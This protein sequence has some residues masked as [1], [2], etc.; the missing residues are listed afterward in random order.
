MVLSDAECIIDNT[1]DETTG[2]TISKMLFG[3]DQK[4]KC[5]D[6]IE[7]F[8]EE[9]VNVESRNHISCRDKAIEKMLKAQDYNKAYYGQK[10][11]SMNILYMK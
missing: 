3:I 5:V 9:N 2:E 6:E 4:G 1:K 10:H 7:Q 11:K 8:L